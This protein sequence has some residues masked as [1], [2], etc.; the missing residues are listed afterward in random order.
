VLTTATL[1]V[2]LN[3]HYNGDVY[4]LLAA[5]RYTAHHGVANRDP[6]L[7][8]SHGREWFDQQW[9]AGLLFYGV[10]LAGGLTLLSILYGLLVGFAVLPLVIG[11]RHK[12]P[13]Q[14][15]GAWILSLPMLF[16][17]LDPRAEGFSLLAFA[18]LLVLTD[19]DRRRGRV[20]WIPLVFVLWANLHAAFLVGLLFLALVVAGAELDRRRGFAERTFSWRFVAIGLALPATLATPLGVRIVDYLRVL[21][22]NKVLPRLTY[23]WD[24]TWQH[25]Y[26]LVY[27]ALVAVYGAWLFAHAPRPRPVEPL[28]VLAGFAIFATTATRQ[29]VWLGPL[30]FYLLRQLGRPGSIAVSRRASLPVSGAAAAALLVWA[31]W[32]SPAPNEPKLLTGAADYAAAHPVPGR[33]AAPPGTGSY[34]LWHAS[35]LRVTIDGRFENYSDA[36]LEGAYDVVDHRG[37]WRARASRWGVTRVITRNPRAIADFVADG[38]LIRYNSRGHD[39]L[40][41]P[42]H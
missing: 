41:R 7:T 21:S 38:W 3:R 14:V 12:Q 6:F 5:G 23:E 33:V 28:L 17:L 19:V 15:V 39:V 13:R 4:W 34:L 8:L 40:D 36:E 42:D 24:P 31:V 10:V 30:C 1:A 35:S 9:L 11:C 2:Y 18:V 25:P 37:A 29:L 22:A 16:A 32:I 27:P 20:W 26:T